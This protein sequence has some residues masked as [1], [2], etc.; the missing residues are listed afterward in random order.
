MRLALFFAVLGACTPPVDSSAAPA[1]DGQWHVAVTTTN[2]FNVVELRVV[3]TN[4]RRAFE[5]VTTPEDIQE[6]KTSTFVRSLDSDATR[7][8]IEEFS[9]VCR[10]QLGP[11]WRNVGI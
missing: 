11:D 7:K 10:R 2:A 3:E 1:E 6:R 5:G 4:I 9:S 8:I